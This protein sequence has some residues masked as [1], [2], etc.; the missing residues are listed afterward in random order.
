MWLQNHVDNT[1]TVDYN[2][3]T[4]ILSQKSCLVNYTI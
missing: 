2:K 4:N 1:M 3:T